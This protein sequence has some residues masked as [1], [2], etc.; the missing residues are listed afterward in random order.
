MSSRS[1]ECD[2]GPPSRRAFHTPDAG[3]IWHVSTPVGLYGQH[4]EAEALDGGIVNLDRFSGH[5]LLI[6]NVASRCGFTPQY[7]ALEQLH[8]RYRERGFAVLGFPC[9]QFGRQEPGTHAEIRRFCS[10]SYDVTFP[11][12]G[13]VDVNGK[14]AHRLFRFLKTQK[15]GPLGVERILW[16]FTKFLVARDGQVLARYSPRTKPAAIESALVRALD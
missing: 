14:A 12:F 7:R 13:K 5:V 4:V 3:T 8:R 11:M 9:D 2:R 1:Q 6:V 16:N 10:E 15:R